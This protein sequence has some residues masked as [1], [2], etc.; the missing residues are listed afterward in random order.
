MGFIVKTILSALIIA[1]ASWLSGRKPVLA[2]FII[3][4]PLMSMLAIL[5]SYLEYRDMNKV[6]QFA[7]SILVAVPLSLTFFIPFILN[8]W[9]KMGFVPT[10]LLAIACV[11]IAFFLHQFI[12]K[13]H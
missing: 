8:K 1:F 7:D 10:Y 9:L 13:S 3:A 2:G 5:F 12:F 4:L 11:F 6:N